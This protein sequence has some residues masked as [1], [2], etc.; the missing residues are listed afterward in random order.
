MFMIIYRH[1]QK[2]SL[3]FFKQKKC[4]NQA[5]KYFFFLTKHYLFVNL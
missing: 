1:G 5:K 3:V 2:F 4:R